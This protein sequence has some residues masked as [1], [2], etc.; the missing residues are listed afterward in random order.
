MGCGA[1][2]AVSTPTPSATAA[3]TM[4]P[5]MTIPATETPTATACASN[6]ERPLRYLAL[7]DSLTI[8]ESV[9]EAE[10]WPVQLVA[11]LREQG[12][13]IEDAEIVARTGWTTAELQDGILLADPQGPYDLVSLLIGVNNQYCGLSQ[14]EYRDELI[15]LLQT[16]VAFADGKPEHVFVVSIPDWGATPFAE[17]RDRAAVGAEIDTFNDISRE[18]AER[19]GLLYID[20]TDISRLALED[21][22]LTAVDGLHPSGKM[23]ALWVA[24]METAV[25]GLLSQE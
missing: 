21:E 4:E 17:G 23:Y 15:G 8:G 3:A 24:R 11:A 7:G 5:T 18:E 14:A 22:L 1:E 16:A 25:C 6:G 12:V 20:I 2:T 10:R 19:R 13:T 9:A